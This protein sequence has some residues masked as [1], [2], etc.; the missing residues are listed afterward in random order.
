MCV[1][2]AMKEAMKEFHVWIRVERLLAPDLFLFRNLYAERNLPRF[3]LLFSFYFL[4]SFRSVLSVGVGGE[5]CLL[6]LRGAFCCMKGKD[7]KQKTRGLSVD[8]TRWLAC[9][10]Y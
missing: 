6:A 3:P 5:S 4:L 7:R 2:R 10:I 1:V 9:I 8:I